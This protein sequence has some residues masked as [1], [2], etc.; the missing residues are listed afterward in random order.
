[1]YS[2]DYDGY[3]PQPA[4][5]W[6]PQLQLYP[7]YIPNWRVFWCPSYKYANNP[8]AT[9]QQ[10]APQT[11]PDAD[12]ETNYTFNGWAYSKSQLPALPIDVGNGKV[13]NTDA[14]YSSYKGRFINDWTSGTVYRHLGGYNVLYLPDFHVVWHLPGQE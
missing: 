6:N 11:G 14:F 13:D 5:Y 2:Q 8:A 3:L 1:M 9:Y 12:H 4:T 7:G 10:Y